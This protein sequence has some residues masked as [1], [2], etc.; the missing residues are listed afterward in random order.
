MWQGFLEIVIVEWCLRRGSLKMVVMLDM[1]FVAYGMVCVMETPG[2]RGVR[3]VV[4]D[5]DC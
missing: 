2:D 3:D 5:G 1:V 4:C